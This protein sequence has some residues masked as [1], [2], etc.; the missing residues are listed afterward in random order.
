MKFFII[1]ALGL[2]SLNLSAQ[3]FNPKLLIIEEI[4]KSI[5][6]DFKLSGEIQRVVVTPEGDTQKAEEEQT[7]T[8]GQKAVAEQLRLSRLRLQKLKGG[9]N[10]QL[11]GKD[12]IQLMLEKNKQKI[13]DQKKAESNSNSDN[14]SKDWMSS[15]QQNIQNWETNKQVEISSWEEEKKKTIAKWMEERSKYLKRIPQY[16]ENLTPIPIPTP[17]VDN[18]KNIKAENEVTPTPTAIPTATPTP[19]IQ[20]IESPVFSDYKIID[21]AFEGPVKDQGKRPTCAAFAGI[22]AVEILLARKDQYQK[23]SEQYLYWSNKPQ[24]KSTPCPQ[25]GSWV[26]DGYK[27]S[28]NS[29]YPDIPLDRDCPYNSQ[30]NFNNNTTQIPLSSGCRN[31]KV[32][33]KSFRQLNS[34]NEVVTAIKNNHPVVSAFKLSENF[35]D[36]SGYVFYKDKTKALTKMD[37]HSSGHAILLIGYMK[38]PKELHLDEGKYCLLTANSWGIGWG[39]GGHACLSERWIEKYKYEGLKFI[40]VESI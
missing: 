18:G 36:N 34:M 2:S 8:K 1:F 9:N 33:V 39:K 32:Q 13:K 6:T 22:R 7:P 38:L 12:K 28:Q 3:P 37:S 27:F 35:Y 26:Y 19:T 4:Q 31:G 11:S 10:V 15:K 14:Q 16:K 20:E 21:G 24:C 25:G 5:I 40:S 23:L 29:P 30:D 17:E